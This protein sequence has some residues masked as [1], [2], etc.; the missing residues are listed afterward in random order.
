MPSSLHLLHHGGK[1]VRVV[2]DDHQDVYAF[3]DQ[4][5]NLLFL[6]HRILIR[7]F[8]EKVG[9]EIV[10]RAGEDVEIPLPTLHDER[11]HGEADERSLARRD[12]VALR[13]AARQRDGEENDERRESQ[14][15]RQYR[16]WPGRR[17]PR[18]SAVVKSHRCLP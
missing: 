18:R 11:V 5:A 14:T 4:I 16:P 2:G 8:Q 12:P 13:R 9:A 3:V 17:N 6:Y 10:G 7:H 1:A 15:A